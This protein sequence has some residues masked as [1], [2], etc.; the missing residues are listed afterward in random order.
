VDCF[1]H[2]VGDPLRV[3]SKKKKD[4]C[5]PVRYSLLGPKWLIDKIKPEKQK[6][7]EVDLYIYIY[8]NL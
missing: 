4:H 8:K 3:C 7:A 2:W 1:T 6:D 5:T